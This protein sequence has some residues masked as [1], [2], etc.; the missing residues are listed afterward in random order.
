MNAPRKP[1]RF[2][3]RA[4]VHHARILLDALDREVERAGADKD[5]PNVLAAGDELDNLRTAFYEMEE[6]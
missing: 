4:V 6:T 5:Q 2:Y 1:A 3:E